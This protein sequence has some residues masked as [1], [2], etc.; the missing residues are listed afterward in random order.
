M[1][2]RVQNLTFYVTSRRIRGGTLAEWVLTFL[3]FVLTLL[4]GYGTYRLLWSPIPHRFEQSHVV[5]VPASDG[6]LRTAIY[7]GVIAGGFTYAGTEPFG[8]I[9]GRPDHER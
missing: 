6:N 5:W 3:L 4:A 8:L 1:S 9:V 2:S 7:R